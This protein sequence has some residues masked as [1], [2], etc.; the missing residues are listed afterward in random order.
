VTIP[1]MP[2][3]R[4][5]TTS[6]CSGT[7]EAGTHSFL[8]STDAELARAALWVD[9]LAT[10]VTVAFYSWIDEGK[11]VALP[12]LTVSA[13]TSVLQI[14]DLDDSLMSVLRIEIVVVG[15]PATLD[16]RVRGRAG[17]GGGSGGTSV[18]DDCFVILDELLIEADAE[19]LVNE[20]TCVDIV[21]PGNNKQQRVATG[22]LVE[23]S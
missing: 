20:D 14:L 13:P 5:K 17:G 10:S 12:S 11:E 8:L 21:S 18:Q 3:T 19:V 1:G 22:S 15:G 23:Y 9:S 6:I 4:G 2:L 7:L 16:L